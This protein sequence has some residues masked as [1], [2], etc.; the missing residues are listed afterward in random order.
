MSVAR[1]GTRAAVVGL[2][3]IASLALTAAP[4]WAGGNS[5]A[6][7]ACEAG[8][9]GTL[10]NQTGL[11]VTFKN[12]GQCTKAGAHGEL[13]GVNAV[14]GAAADGVFPVTFSAFGLQPNST[15][16]IVPRYEPSG[17]ATAGTTLLIGGKGEDPG[18]TLSPFFCEILTLG[19]AASI[20]VQVTTAA[21]REP[22]LEF[23][24]PTGC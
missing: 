20:V 19:T 6:A 15:A 17:L 21:G 23:P 11:P 3:V 24:G 7:K 1:I 9:T 12:E 18:S 14:A 16:V 5:A 10:L 22:T 13:V 8:Y 4:S 2:G